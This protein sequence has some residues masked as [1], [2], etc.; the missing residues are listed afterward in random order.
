ERRRR[1]RRKRRREEGRGDP[2]QRRIVGRDQR[3][4]G[5][6]ERRSGDRYRSREGGEEEWATVV[7]SAFETVR[8]LSKVANV[9]C[10]D[11]LMMTYPLETLQ[12]AEDV[13]LSCLLPR[14]TGEVTV[15]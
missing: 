13:E 2:A 1:E 7:R 5:S 15:F 3:R 4:K 10:T 9:Y 11:H 14:H 12:P 6:R 8:C